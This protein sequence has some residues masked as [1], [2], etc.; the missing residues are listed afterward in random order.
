LAGVAETVEKA[1]WQ[2]EQEVGEH[3]GG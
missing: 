3:I 2:E 1:E